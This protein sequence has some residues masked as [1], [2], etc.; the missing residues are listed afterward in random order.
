MTKFLHQ[1]SRSASYVSSNYCNNLNSRFVN[2]G[3]CNLVCSNVGTTIT[4][5]TIKAT[6]SATTIIRRNFALK[7]DYD[8]KKLISFRRRRRVLGIPSGPFLFNLALVT[9]LGY[10]SGYYIFDEPLKE[11]WK[12]GGVG[13]QRLKE[14]Q[15]ALEAA[16]NNNDK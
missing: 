2:N 6:G 10:S 15:E 9:A 7:I 5:T 1:L 3:Y 11:Y 4:T 8:P 14:R 12:E 13:Q 16:K